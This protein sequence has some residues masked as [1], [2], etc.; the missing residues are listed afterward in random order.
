MLWARAGG[1]L[2]ALRK[3]LW[4]VIDPAGAFDAEARPRFEREAYE[5]NARV[6]SWLAYALPPLCAAAI[7]LVL[8]RP[9]TDPARVAWRF[10][11][12]G[13]SAAPKL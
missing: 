11:V 5:S 1:L 12:I 13:I 7:V 3:A 4:D 6:L 8:R 10:G 2:L 9:E